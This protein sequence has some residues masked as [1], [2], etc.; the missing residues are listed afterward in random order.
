MGGLG[1][2]QAEQLAAAGAQWQPR[3]LPQKLPQAWLSCLLLM[4]ALCF[5]VG[6]FLYQNDPQMVADPDLYAVV[7]M[8]LVAISAFFGV[9][10]ARL[11]DAQLASGLLKPPRVALR[12]QPLLAPLIGAV[13]VTVLVGL[14]VILLGRFGYQPLVN[15]AYPVLPEGLRERPEVYRAFLYLGYSLLGMIVAFCSRAFRVGFGSLVRLLGGAGARFFWCL[16]ALAAGVGAQ[17]LV[18]GGYW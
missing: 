14:G 6:A 10:R 5:G 18:V 12:A 1:S 13:V 8:L 11:R 17:Y 16:V 3:Y 2:G 4:L 15:A 7:F 9:F